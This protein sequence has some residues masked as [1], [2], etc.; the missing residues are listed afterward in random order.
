VSDDRANRSAKAGAVVVCRV[1]DLPEP[2]MTAEDH[3]RKP[4]AFGGT[5]DP[6]NRLWLCASCHKRIHRVQGL[7]VH[8]KP[9]EAYDLCDQIFPEAPS[10]RGRLWAFANE[11]AKAEVLAKESFNAHRDHVRVSLDVDI[12]VW[13]TLKAAA[14][15]QK[16]SAKEL[17]VR[18][19]GESVKQRGN[20]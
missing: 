16:T 3:H 20:N 17:A 18:I 14:K 6:E 12:T 10:K 19:L 4:R 1:C 2:L 5:D 13:E 11:A 15:E 9:S 8:N 7:L